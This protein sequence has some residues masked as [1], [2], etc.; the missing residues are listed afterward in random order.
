M[1]YWFTSDFHFNHKRICEY[2]H[3]PF[4]SVEEMNEKIIDNWNSVV[5]DDASVFYLGDF[6]F[7][8]SQFIRNTL[9]RLK[10]RI[11]FIRGNHDKSLVQFLKGIN[12]YTDLSP[13]LTYLGDYAEV[14]INDQPIV[15]CHYPMITWARKSYGS[16]MLSGHS[17]YNL[18]ATRKEETRFGKVLDVGVDGNNF[19]PYSFEELEKIMDN[20]PIMSSLD[21]LQDH[22]SRKEED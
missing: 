3:R 2:S 16:W 4:K 14:T 6:A 15:L 20:K 1:N 19:M 10:G 11:S 13:R 5:T 9:R 18:K 12:N 7:A 22:H 17:H 21:V 8:D